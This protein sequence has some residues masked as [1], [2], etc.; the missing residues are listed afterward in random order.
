MMHFFSTSE[1]QIQDRKNVYRTV[2]SR[3][4]D[5]IVNYLISQIEIGYSRPDHMVSV[6]QAMHACLVDRYPAIELFMTPDLEQV[7]DRL[8]EAIRCAEDGENY[9]PEAA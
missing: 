3:D 9:N 7:S 4:P 8:V 2:F 5:Q 6:L 1:R